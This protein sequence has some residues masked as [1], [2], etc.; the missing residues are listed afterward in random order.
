MRALFRIL[1]V[2]GC[3][4]AAVVI[5]LAI[6]YRDRRPRIYFAAEDG[7]TN[8]IFLYL[9]SGSNVNVNINCYPFSD[10]F[11]CAPLLDV[12]L[13]NGQI[14]TVALLLKRGA[15]P[16]QPDSRGDTPLM[17][18]IGR[19]KNEVPHERRTQVLKML[20]NAGAAPNMAAQSQYAYT[21]LIEAAS[22]GQTDMVRVLLE[23]GAVVNATNKVGQTGLHLAGNAEVAKLLLA[24]GANLSARDANGDTPIEYA[25]R[26]RYRN[27]LDI[28]T[29]APVWTNH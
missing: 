19:I 13:Q 28:L 10:R 18:A 15:N 4:F 25:M 17:W 12:A 1:L 3:L 2:L 20:L 14:E 22:L 6:V 5:L 26:N 9:A 16:N 11:L 8:S 23:R 29:N 21:P 7:D 24:A 27:T